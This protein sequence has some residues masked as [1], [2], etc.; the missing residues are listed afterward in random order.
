MK[1]KQT[2]HE[3]LVLFIEKAQKLSELSFT[4]S[5]KDAGLSYSWRAESGNIIFEQRGP[6]DESI[7]AFVLTL[8][9]F[10]QDKDRISFRCMSKLV[11]NPDLSANWKERFEEARSRLNKFLDSPPNPV[12]ED[13]NC[14]ILRR[15][16]LDV[17]LYGGLAHADKDKKRVFDNWKAN[18]FLFPFIHHEFIAMVLV[19][20]ASID[21]V[22]YWTAKELESI[23]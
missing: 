13:G 21:H 11:N 16:I 23:T 19:I 10:L 14:C 17:V 22:A 6:S 20:F 2:T 7:D 18:E 1:L 3:T 8:R 15:F 5:I 12:I 9:L 4:K